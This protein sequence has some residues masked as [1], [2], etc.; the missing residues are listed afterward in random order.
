MK[1]LVLQPLIPTSLWLAMALAAGGLLTWYAWSSRRRLS[2]GRW[3]AA[4]LLMGITVALPLGLLLNPTW[5]EQLPPP[6]GKPR[7]VVLID[8]SASMQTRDQ[9]HDR[10]R[11]DEAAAIATALDRQLGE[12]FDVALR[13]FSGAS[14]Q[15]QPVDAGQLTSTEPTGHS[16]D[17]A[18]AITSSLDPDR[19]QG[20][21]LLLL[22]DGI[23]NAGEE[24]RVLEAAQ[25]AK[26]IAAP[27]YTRTLGGQAA[28]RDLAIEAEVPQDVAFVGQ[29]V[30][31]RARLTAQGFA[32]AIAKVSLVADGKT[33]DE[34]EVRLSGEAAHEVQFQ[35]QHERSG[36]FRY[37]LQADPLPG[38]ATTVNNSSAYVLRVLDEPI[39]ILLLEGKP[40]WDAKFL[41]RT[42]L[43]DPAVELTSVVRLAEG[44]F[45]QRQFQRPAADS[46]TVPA[47]EPAKPPKG[48]VEAKTASFARP[49]TA[50][51]PTSLATEVRA[52]EGGATTAD[53]TGP[54]A[55]RAEQ[56]SIVHDGGHWLADPKA[57]AAYQVIVLGRDAEAFLTD[58]ALA[59]LRRWVSR[60]AG[61]LVCFRGPPEAQLSQRLAQMMPV[62][63]T[64]SHAARFHLKLTADGESMHWLGD[65]SGNLQGGSSNADG[66]AAHPSSDPLAGM[67]A[68]AST[69][70]PSAALPQAIVWATGQFGGGTADTPVVTALPYG[71][72]RVVVVEGAGMWHWAFLPPAQQ[73]NSQIYAALWGSLT[74]WLATNTGLLPSQSWLLRTDK[75]EFTSGESA[76]GVLLV[77]ESALGKTAPGVELVSDRLPKPK[78]V[79]AVASGDEP[80]AFRVSFGR[81]EPGRYTAR[82]VGAPAGDPA[83]IAA[84]EVRPDVREVLQLDADSALM[85]RLAEESGGAALVSASPEE[86]SRHLE[87]YLAASHPEQV[88]TTTAWDRWWVLAAMLGTWGT[89]WIVRRSSGLV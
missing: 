33:I 82:V 62:R 40:Y 7:L 9:P 63:W 2:R 6:E 36:V 16:T 1:T 70:Q 67:P 74:R 12:R 50:D 61:S 69:E 23:D 55:T 13:T 54:S 21:A 89:T 29:K 31:I 81:L 4:T 56:W 8:A 79:S 48:T 51:K 83:A 22:S 26:A 87:Q 77:R 17:L 58:E 27:I 43:S 38:E 85:K 28:V 25:K 34:R 59:Q 32:G 14:G 3:I 44:R 20:E 49:S 71:T 42:L 53:S 35:T 45:L 52:T 10:S 57:L 46:A 24:S 76:A 65:R 41:T 18:L 19:P 5:L 86:V 66:R 60:D 11:F 72:G 84:F 15:V 39:R 78:T 68:L 80:G 75:T 47:A 64:P 88:R 30:P 37:E 73:Q